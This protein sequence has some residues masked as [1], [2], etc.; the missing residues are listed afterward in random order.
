MRKQAIARRRQEGGPSWHYRM[1]TA[2][3]QPQQ[4]TEPGGNSTITDIVHSDPERKT[5]QNMRKL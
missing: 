4:S 3:R 5:S 1:A 2:F